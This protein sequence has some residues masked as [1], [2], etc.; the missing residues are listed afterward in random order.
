VFS[1]DKL[2]GAGEEDMAG[3]EES[4]KLALVGCGGIAQAHWRGIREIATRVRVTSVVETHDGRRADMA[5]R[6]GARPFAT[7]DEALADGDFDAVDIMLPHDLHEAAAMKAFAAGKHV[8]LEKPLA[9]DLAS[10]ERIIAAGKALPTGRVFMVAEQAQYWMDVVKAR[11]LIDAGAIG[12]V[13]NA[14]ACFY[15][16]LTPEAD[17]APPPWR[18]RLAK[19]GGG[20]TIDGGAHWIRPLRMM[21]GEVEEVI[22]V[23][24][25]HVPRM[26]GESWSQ[27]ILRFRS[28]V[29]AMFDA[30]NVAAP[31]APYDL[32]RVTGD[33]GEL[34]ITGGA[35]G[36][37]R[38]F[39]AGSPR[40][41]TVMDA[42][43]T[44]R[45]S[46]GA[47]IKDFCDAVLDGAPIAAQPEYSLGEIRTA[48]A[49]YAS[50]KSGRWE[51]VWA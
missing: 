12:A 3:S 45:D 33:A 25:R 31:F 14:K 34:V 39:N 9:H 15:D 50:V 36:E 26:E 49:L 51:K 13:L 40:G 29:T 16:R 42:V 35:H 22:G 24:G 4:L 46:Y 47:E 43:A 41:E 2:A 1:L 10:A 32:F 8:L 21:L 23:T 44:K 19:A 28:G 17:G 7:L 11:E 27:S 48:L 38:L 6:T 18:Y 20:L 37:L 5:E 30:M